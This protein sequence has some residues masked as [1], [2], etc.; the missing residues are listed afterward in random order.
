[1][2]CPNCGKEINDPGSYCPECGVAIAST[3]QT[4][5][6]APDPHYSAPTSSVPAPD[7]Y[8]PAPAPAPIQP[9]KKTS[10]LPII[11]AISVVVLLMLG[12][13]GGFG[14]YAL[15]RSNAYDSAVEAFTTA[16]YY[17]NQAFYINDYRL[18]IE[19]YE[20]AYQEFTD[21]GDY[22]DSVYY[23]GRCQDRITLCEKNIDYLTATD[24]YYAGSYKEAKALFQSL[25]G[26]S[27]SQFMIE[28]CD[29]HILFNEGVGLYEQGDYSSA[30]EVFELL[31]DQGF[32][33]ADEYCLITNYAIA[34]QLYKQGSLYEAYLLF[35]SLGSFDDA[36]DRAEG[37]TISFPNTGEIYHNSDFVSSAVSLVIDGSNMPF[38]RYIKIYS[39]STL[40]SRI[41]LNPWSSVTVYLPS[42]TYTIRA[43]SGTLW[44]GEEIMFGDEGDYSTMVFEDGGTTTFFR[45]NYIY[46][47]TLYA[48]EDS[49]IKS[50]DI[51]REHF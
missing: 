2:Y 49:N 16:E 4:A 47:L 38:V 23:A 31:S 10:L 11:I 8:Y 13:A 20:S 50:Q 34:D 26:F 5:P 33:L 12:V 24:L 46:T 14:V 7:Q 29:L 18:T 17:Y 25:S 39:G 6:P 1:M 30:L 27:D 15:L 22:K 51:D 21:L 44:F 41:F 48:T 28:L 40:V 32:E 45:N 19:N 43:A 3:I 35:R 37:C 9:P 42:D 36:N